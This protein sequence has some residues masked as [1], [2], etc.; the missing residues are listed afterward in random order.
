MQSCGRSEASARECDGVVDDV[1]AAKT[2]VTHAAAAAAVAAS[3]S[4]LS[5]PPGENEVFEVNTT[6]E[7]DWDELRR[8]G[9]EFEHENIVMLGSKALSR[10]FF[11]LLSSSLSP[12]AGHTVHVREAS[13]C[14]AGG[15]AAG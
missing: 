6:N 4:R 10:A 3:I 7:I 12:L 14:A 2:S 13:R 11:P 5:S 8:V 9:T 1:V 15:Y